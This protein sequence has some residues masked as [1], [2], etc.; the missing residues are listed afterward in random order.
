MLKS[1]RYY[2]R[3]PPVAKGPVAKFLPLCHLAAG[4]LALI[5]AIHRTPPVR[6]AAVIWAVFRA[7]P[8][9]AE[10]FIC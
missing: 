7:S 3:G 10:F 1:F 5:R 6:S 9:I 8:D 4:G 2:Q